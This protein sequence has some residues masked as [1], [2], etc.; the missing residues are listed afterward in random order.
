MEWEV[1]WWDRNLFVFLWIL[2]KITAAD[3]DLEHQEEAQGRGDAG[4]ES[5]WEASGILVEK[6]MSDAGSLLQVVRVLG[7][8]WQV[9]RL[10][11]E[12]LCV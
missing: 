9:N 3:M 10:P 4:I 5:N 6:G 1:Q 8:K 11:D 7:N 2:G 12:A